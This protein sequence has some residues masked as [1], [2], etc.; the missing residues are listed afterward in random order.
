MSA[1]REQP[2]LL[3]PQAQL[4]AT[5][6]ELA[7]TYG[8]AQAEGAVVKEVPEV[9]S[10]CVHNASRSQM[11]QVG[12]DLGQEFPKPLTDDVV[13]AADVVVSMGCGDACATYPG[14]RYLDWMLEDPDVQPLEVVR[15]I[16]DDVDRRVRELLR[17][18]VPSA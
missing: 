14:K 9:Q 12:V 2:S 8:G 7:K 6:R 11:A 1:P 13:A 4:T 10:L 17:D 3:M 15:V 18:L 5:A 16:R